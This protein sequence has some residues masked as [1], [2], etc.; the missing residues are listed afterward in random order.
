MYHP[1]RKSAITCWQALKTWNNLIGHRICNI[2]DVI[3]IIRSFGRSQDDEPRAM[4]IYVPFSVASALHAHGLSP[5]MHI[6]F[7]SSGRF[8]WCGFHILEL[9]K[10]RVS[11][12]LWSIWSAWPANGS[13]ID[14]LSIF[15]NIDCIKSINR[16]MLC[17]CFLRPK[18]TN[19]SATNF[20]LWSRLHLRQ[21]TLCGIMI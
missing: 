20:V 1:W 9:Y 7:E 18:D 3:K 15:A 21:I 12:V 19:Q 14:S 11:L 2:P 17:F 5:C 16:V 6:T 13:A 10:A 4:R 8:I